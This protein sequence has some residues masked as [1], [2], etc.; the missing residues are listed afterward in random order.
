MCISCVLVNP[1]IANMP[2]LRQQAIA[3]NKIVRLHQMSSF[4]RS[5][6]HMFDKYTL[7]FMGESI[8]S[9]CNRIAVVYVRDLGT[10]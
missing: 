10:I 6:G 2:H 7:A 5:V 1:P 8:R 9:M 3:I 4:L